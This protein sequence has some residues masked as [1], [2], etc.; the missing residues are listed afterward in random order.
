MSSK[1]CDQN[2]QGRIVSDVTVAAAVQAKHLSVSSIRHTTTLYKDS[3][4]DV[5]QGGRTVAEL[6]SGP[7][8]LETLLPPEECRVT[9]PGAVA[10]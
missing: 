5:Q 4:T 7:V 1:E 8:G 6:A 3:N 10:A 2:V 9:A